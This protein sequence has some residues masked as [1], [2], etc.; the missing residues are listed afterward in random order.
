[1]DLKALAAKVEG[2]GIDTVLVVFPDVFGRLVGKRLDARHFLD[3]VAD[4]GT[5]GCN[6]LLTLNI[7]MDPLDGFKLANWEAGFGDFAMTPDLSTVRLLPWQQATALVISD[8]HHENGQA[9]AEAPRSVLR[10]QVE[11]LAAKG[12]TCQCASELEFF[13]YNTTYHEAFKS[14]YTNLVPSS[15]YR[16]DYHTMQPTRDE[17]VIGAL[18]R[19]M[20]AAGVPVESSKGEWGKGQHELNFVH[21]QPLPMA[22]GHVVFKQGAKEI[23]EQHG[24]CLSF[25]PKIFAGEAGSSCHIHVSVWQD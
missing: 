6:Y 10:R 3:H 11:R 22:D 12:L 21:D 2:G 4:G 1:M 16:I 15:D 7:E 23:A 20:Q 19:Q 13:L 17:P 24:K 9:V 8:L 18:R 5:H 25:M 14:G